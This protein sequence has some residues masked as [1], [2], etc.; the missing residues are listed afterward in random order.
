MGERLVN[1]KEHVAQYLYYYAKSYMQYTDK[2]CL[3]QSYRF[4]SFSVGFSQNQG[5]L[6][7]VWGPDDRVLNSNTLENKQKGG[8]FK[9][10]R[11]L[12]LQVICGIIV[13]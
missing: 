1:S 12:V 5:L 11:S 4:F 9:G 3:Y 10:A 2:L 8:H 7:S 13:L 6:E